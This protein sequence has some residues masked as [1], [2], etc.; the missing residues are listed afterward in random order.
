[1]SSDIQERIDAGLDWSLLRSFLAIARS[2]SLSAAARRTGISQPTLGRHV[3]A[4]EAQTGLALFTRARSGLSLTA[5]GAALVP[6]A[7]A[8]AEAAARLSLAAEGRSAAI[9]GTVRITAS[10]IVSQ[11]LLPP[12][13]A[14]LR[15]EEPGIEIEL[16][17]SDTTENLLFR[18]ADIALRMFRPEQLDIVT[19]HVADL[20]MG[21]YAAKDYLD[22]AGRPET[23]EAL[24]RL[25]FVGFDR[26]DAIIRLF[27][28]FGI[29]RRR[30]DFPLRCDDQIVYWNLVRAGL[31]VGGMQR[32][33]GDA[34]PLV[35][36]I[37]LLDLPALPVW[38]AA[39]AALRSS[40]RLRRVWDHLADGFRSLPAPD[41]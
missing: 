41:S 28:A 17:P 31:G 8:M 5:A 11:F 7:A 1:M 20:A 37:G 25:D 35:E 23:R 15:R 21:L 30:E 34:E 39:P 3:A 22:R 29:E 2:G 19:S 32:S 10:R 4:L 36:R 33:I 24:L 40:P 14:R 6:H 9:A 13:L 12:M 38:I 18:E 27:R 26:S 16:V